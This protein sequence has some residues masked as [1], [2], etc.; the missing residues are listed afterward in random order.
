MLYMMVST[1]T[2]MMTDSGMIN[3]RISL[4][5]EQ[6]K[7]LLTHDTMTQIKVKT[8]AAM[9]APIEED[10]P[11]NLD[12]RAAA[13]ARVMRAHKPVKALRPSIARLTVRDISNNQVTRMLSDESEHPQ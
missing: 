13:T 3:C 6:D 2:E 11:M 12:C 4:A 9:M 8:L 10:E 7:Q 5:G 1:S